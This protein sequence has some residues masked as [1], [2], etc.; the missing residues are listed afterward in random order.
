MN[1]LFAAFGMDRDKIDFNKTNEETGTVE[2]PWESVEV[3]KWI[4][5]FWLCA[6]AR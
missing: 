2:E 1:E 5:I 3:R 4:F 6:A